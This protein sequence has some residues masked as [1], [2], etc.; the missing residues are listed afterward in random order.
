M[1]SRREFPF[2]RL[3]VWGIFVM[4]TVV[5]IIQSMIPDIY[6]STLDKYSW[7][8]EAL[9]LATNYLYRAFFAPLI[10]WIMP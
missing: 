1:A 9:P 2:L 3:R 8:F 10:Y 6:S 4:I 5:F 7:N